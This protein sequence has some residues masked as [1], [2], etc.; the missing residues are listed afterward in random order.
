MTK[1]DTVEALWDAEEEVRQF[2]ARLSEADYDYLSYVLTGD[3]DEDVLTAAVRA[4]YHWGMD[5]VATDPDDP[6]WIRAEHDTLVLA[7]VIRVGLA[8]GNITVNTD[9]EPVFGPADR[10]DPNGAAVLDRLSSIPLAG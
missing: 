2:C 4:A 9:P 8:E 1:A 6:D 10:I 5:S 3:S 7:R